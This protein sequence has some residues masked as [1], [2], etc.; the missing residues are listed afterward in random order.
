MQSSWGA[1]AA[2][3]RRAASGHA[4]PPR[5]DRAGWLPGEGKGLAPG[6]TATLAE[7]CDFRPPNPRLQD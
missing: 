4:W 2:S 6:R 3:R 7:G 1:Q 5:E